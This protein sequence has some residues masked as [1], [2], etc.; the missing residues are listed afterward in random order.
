MDKIEKLERQLEEARFNND[1]ER[2]NAELVRWKN[3]Y[4]GKCYSSNLF[5]RRTKSVNATIIRVTDVTINSSYCTGW[6]EPDINDYKTAIAN[7]Y[8]REVKI[9]FE[10]I[11]FCVNK[12]RNSIYL[13]INNSHTDILSFNKPKYEISLE[14]YLSILNTVRDN[15]YNSG[16]VIS[17]TVKD[18]DVF[19]DD[20]LKISCLEKTGIKLLEITNPNTLLLLSFHPFV[21]GNKIIVSPESKAILTDEITK[22]NNHLNS[23]VGIPESYRVIENI[24]RKLELLK[25]ILKQMI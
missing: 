8:G 20:N 13:S 4:F 23:W 11:Y 7:S 9:E 15:I 14:K 22:L 21:Y 16:F 2:I 19:D 25:E 1:V 6:K 5:N 3:A 24:N 18:F 10:H 12:E 17:D